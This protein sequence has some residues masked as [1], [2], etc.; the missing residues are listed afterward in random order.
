M[1]N[2]PAPALVLLDGDRDELASWTRS[3]AIRAGLA[4][5]ARVVLLASEGVA[6]ARIAAEVGTTTTSVWKWRNRYAEAGLPGLVDASRW[7]IQRRFQ[8]PTAP[9]YSPLS[10]RKKWNQP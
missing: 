4:L 9:N 5:R 2:S 10:A 8:V 7:L 6:N 3:T 1:A